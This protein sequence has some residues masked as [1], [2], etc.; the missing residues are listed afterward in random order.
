MTFFL[1]ILVVFWK[2]LFQQNKENKKCKEFRSV[3]A[4]RQH[5]VRALSIESSRFAVT[6]RGI[7]RLS[8]AFFLLR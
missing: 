3:Q 8:S 6:F 4:L 7:N 5:K 1:N 2:N